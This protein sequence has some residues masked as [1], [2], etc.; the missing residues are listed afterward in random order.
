MGR[1][2]PLMCLHPAGEDRGG[3][4]GEEA[5]LGCPALAINDLSRALY[6][7]HA[8]AHSV[9]PGTYHRHLE[10]AEL[11]AMPCIVNDAF[12]LIGDEANTILRETNARST[13]R[14]DGRS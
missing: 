14:P 1:R 8:L 13:A 11:V 3:L 2:K 7:I 6:E 10:Y 9:Q 4:L 5:F 12:N